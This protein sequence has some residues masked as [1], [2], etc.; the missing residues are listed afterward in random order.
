MFDDCELRG[1]AHLVWCQS[2]R[3]AQA[4][5]A[6]LNKLK[7]DDRVN[8][9]IRNLYIFLLRDGKWTLLLISH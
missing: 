4:N 7:E 5:I 2:N 1:S 9:D 3:A 6:V 8:I